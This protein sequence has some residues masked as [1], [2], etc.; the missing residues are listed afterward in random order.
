MALITGSRLGS[1]EIISLLGAG[2]MGEVYRARDTKLNR[3]VAV[4]VLPEAYASDPERISRFTREAQAV[5]ALKHSGIAGIHELAEADP[6][7]GSGQAAIKYLVLELIEGDTLAERL[8]RGAIPPEEALQI[9]KQL[10]EALEAAHEKGICHRDLKP[11]NI[12]LTPEGTVKILDF[13]LAKFLQTGSAAGNLTHSPTLSLAGTYPGLIL[14]TAGYM[15]PEQAKGFEADQRS[16]IFSF[17]CILFEMLTG[18]QAFEGETASE[19][20]A[21]VLKSD[22]DLATLPPRLNPRL[23]ETLK[24]CLEKSPKK[25]WHAVGDVRNEIEAVM[26]RAIVVEEPRVAAATSRPLWKRAL[27][28]AAFTTIGAL[29]AGYAAWTLKPDPPRA[30]GRFTVSLAEGFSSASRRV[31]DMSPDGSRI[32]YLSGNRLYVREVAALEPRVLVVEASLGLLTTPTFSPDGQWIAYGIGV[33]GAGQLKRIA[34]TGGAAVTMT[35]LPAPPFGMTWSDDGIL[36]GQGPNGIARV[37]PD[38]GTPDTV[39]KAASDEMLGSPQLLPGGGAILYSVKKTADSWDRA[40]IAVQ[41][42]GRDNRTVLVNGGMDGRYVPTG[43]L[44]YVLNGVMLAQRFDVQN[45]TVQGGPV[46]V[47]EGVRRAPTSNASGAAQLAFSREGGL[48]YVPGAVTSE[49]PGNDL[50]LFD[51]KGGIEPLKLPAGNY[52]APRLSRD[53]KFVAFQTDD[54]KEAVVWVYDLSGA[55]AVRRLTFQ[56]KNRAPL[57]SPDGQWIVFQ[58]DREG[59]LAVYRQR[60]DGSG[61]AERLTK[62][63][64]GIEHIP[65][66]WSRDG[67]TLLLTIRTVKDQRSTLATMST[68]DL[69]ITPIPRVESTVLINAT[70]SPDGKWIAYQNRHETGNVVLVEPFPPTGAQYLLPRA[71]AGHPTWS[72]KGDELV[73]NFGPQQSAIISVTTKPSFGFGKPADFPRAGRTEPNPAVSPRAIDFMPDGQ[74][75]IGIV[76]PGTGSAVASEFVVVLNWFEELRAR[77]PR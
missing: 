28:A 34:V 73:V 9:A 45:L 38:G 7:T 57:W 12:K 2:G 59:D 63:D 47:I 76:A 70:F 42:L 68:K 13:G 50:A 53:G 65:Q 64:P 5:A 3:E 1:L 41:P 48:V 35:A 71:S 6:S 31:I 36:V 69:K 56:G 39:I 22:V 17:G 37:S 4:K 44:V 75:F 27:A 29:I 74:R 33:D 72:P 11:A 8:K 32:A 66:D 51:R 46:P 25:R 49:T 16:D 67:A 18:R 43:H 60:A 62:P 52:R 21:S 24:R 20:L 61:V 15:S 23:I 30:V 26:G 54:E 40:Q 77:V 14:G 55:Q 19:I 10:L 58:S